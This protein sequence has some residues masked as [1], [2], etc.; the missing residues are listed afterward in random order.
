MSRNQAKHPEIVLI[1]DLDF[2]SAGIFEIYLVPIILFIIG[3]LC[4]LLGIG[5]GEMIGP[6]V[7]IWACCQWWLGLPRPSWRRATHS[8]MSPS[9]C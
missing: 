8:S 2:G 9:T 3:V 4:S 1:G 7:L 6:M 5:G